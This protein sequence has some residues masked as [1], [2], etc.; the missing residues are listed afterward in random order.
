MRI[1]L[2]TYQFPPLSGGAARYSGDLAF[3]L[4]KHFEVD[5][6]CNENQE[7]DCKLFEDFL[8]VKGA[9][10]KNVWRI[11]KVKEKYDIVYATELMAAIPTYFLARKCKAKLIVTILGNDFLATRKSSFLKFCAKWVFRY[12]SKIIVISN[13]SAKFVF[14]DMPELANK[15]EIINPPIKRDRFEKE[16][17]PIDKFEGKLVIL[18]AARLINKKGQKIMV[19]LMPRILEK[20]P[21]A[22]YVIVGKGR[23][24]D[25]IKMEI[26]NLNLQNSVFLEGFVSEED[27]LRYYKRADVFVQYSN[28]VESEGEFEGFGMTFLEAG[29]NKTPAITIRGSGADDTIVNGLTGFIANDVEEFVNSLIFLLNN[30][31][32]RNSMSLNYYNWIIRNCVWDVRIKEIVRVLESV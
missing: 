5:V 1:A 16:V 31:E 7:G 24:E 20:V 22:I 3:Y 28:F 10:Y 25:N 8:K 9:T 4:K 18:Q 29:I 13:G 12:A 27:L 21:N 19:N 17:E 14:E 26:N 32:I 15:I 2:V 23:D 6:Y 30:P 11:R